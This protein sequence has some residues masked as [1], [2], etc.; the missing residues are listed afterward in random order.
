[1]FKRPLLT[2]IL[3]RLRE[4]RRFIQVL[5]G[6]R[7]VGKTTLAEQA[8]AELAVPCHYASADDAA[9]GGAI[10]LEQQWDIGRIRARQ[11]ATL[12][13]EST[14][15]GAIQV[16]DDGQPIVILP[17]GPTVGGYLKIGVVITADLPR[18]T[19]VPLGGEVRFEWVA[20]TEAQRLAH[21]AA[22]ELARLI[23]DIRGGSGR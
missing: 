4:P 20:V 2:T 12:P 22:D 23:H 11:T 19:Q 6:P 17:D 21:R 5:A 14:S 8:M 16:P 1:M 10:W 15:V 18:F 7:Q 13:S 3:E 9:T